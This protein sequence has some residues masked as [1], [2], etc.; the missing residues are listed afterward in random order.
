[1]KTLTS[2]EVYFL[3]KELQFLVSSKIDQIYGSGREVLLQLH[4]PG[5]G[6]VFFRI[7]PNCVYLASY[8]QSYGTPTGFFMFLRKYLSNARLRSIKQRDSERVL[9]IEFEKKEKFILIIELFS[10]GNVILCKENYEI[11]NPLER[12]K[13]S[14]REVKKGVLYT[15]PK[16]K[17]NFLKMEIGEFK[18]FLSKTNKKN[19]VK[20]L[21]VDLGLGG[22]YS[23]EICFLAKIDKNKVPKDINEKQAE[24]IFKS[25]K[26]ILDKKI[27]AEIID[28][29]KDVV[30]FS[31]EFYK[32]SEKK[33]FNNFNE[34]LDFYFSEEE[35]PLSEEEKEHNKKLEKL[36]TI[37]E[38]QG[39]IV[40]EMKAKEREATKKA[41]AI[42]IKYN[43]IKGILTEINK[44]RQKYNWKEIKERLKNHKIIKEVDA[45]EK[46]IMVEI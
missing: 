35:R 29:K 40:E 14:Q 18:E 15:C 46:R 36:N 24:I 38:K 34:A 33:T 16:S 11:I 28:K 20:A 41:E 5:K 19:L 10:K 6:K 39:K 3:L 37:L 27:K 21:A 31:L 4:V 30:P 26:K 8:K 12:Q 42:Y 44:A 22:V 45:K 13:W 43:L 32:N 23:E 1:M 17:Y 7:L 2:L 25:L 9:E